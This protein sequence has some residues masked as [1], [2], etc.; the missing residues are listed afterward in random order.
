[1]T[2]TVTARGPIIS[3]SAQAY[4]YALSFDL[5]CPGKGDKKPVSNVFETHFIDKISQPANDTYAAAFARIMTIAAISTFVAPIGVISNGIQMSYHFVLYRR[6]EQ[7]A[8]SAKWQQV[9]SYA[10]A[11]FQDLI[12][13]V[14]FGQ[15]A[16]F[17][18]LPNKLRIG[19]MTMG[20]ASSIYIGRNFSKAAFG[21]SSAEHL[22]S[23]DKAVNLKKYGVVGAD[24]RLIFFNNDEYQKHAQA[25]DARLVELEGKILRMV[26]WMQKWLP[27]DEKLRPDGPVDLDAMLQHIDRVKKKL[28]NGQTVLFDRWEMMFKE[29]VKSWKSDR[30]LLS[31]FVW[32]YHGCPST[33]NQKILALFLA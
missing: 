19:W 26:Q 5:L 10:D 22:V 24:G 32:L 6:S 20:V 7:E 29:A 8:K 15:A 30:Q 17:I 18:P 16:F 31:Q 14:L 4:L 21:L 25:L 13:F 33:V 2:N 1:M 3:L 27:A 12:C 28:G 9:A 23:Y 11:C